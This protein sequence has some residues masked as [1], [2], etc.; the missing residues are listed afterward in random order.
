MRMSDKDFYQL[1]GE[2]LTSTDRDLYVSEWSTSSIF[3]ED[4]DLLENAEYLGHLWDVAHMSVK[5]ICKA[6]GF[7]QAAL[8][9]HFCIKKRTVENW[10]GG[11]NKCPD[12]TRLMM[13][14]CLGLLTR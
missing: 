8:A 3:P 7:T 6:A 5:D 9:Q 14:E 1:W 11:A 13:A 4:S 12:H 2:A 10:C